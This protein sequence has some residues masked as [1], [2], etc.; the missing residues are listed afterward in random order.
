M[1]IRR[2]S[3]DPIIAAQAPR[4]PR[5]SLGEMVNYYLKMEPHLFKE[6][7]N[8]QFERIREEREA[9]A[10]AAKER[11]KNAPPASSDKSELV[12]YRCPLCLPQLSSAGSM[13]SLGLQQRMLEL[14]TRESTASPFMLTGKSRD[15]PHLVC[16][17]GV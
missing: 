16:L 2:L 12:L 11:E 5:T 15:K 4:K 8:T 10:A 9:T 1:S 7:V 17:M 3:D 14:M 6:A 13:Q